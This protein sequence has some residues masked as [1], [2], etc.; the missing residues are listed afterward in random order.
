MQ[1]DFMRT[2]STEI[3][4][5]LRV[6]VVVSTIAAAASGT[7][8]KDTGMNEQDPGIGLSTIEVVAS[9]GEALQPVDAPSPDGKEIYSVLR[10]RGR[11]A[12][13]GAH[14]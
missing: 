14:S 9:G 8:C 11:E 5:L 1:G 4:N 12:A 2:N 10:S 3:R 7:A 13:R 6:G